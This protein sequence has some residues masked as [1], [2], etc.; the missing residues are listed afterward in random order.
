MT[1]LQALRTDYRAR[2]AQLLDLVASP[3]AT[4]RQVR[5]VL[6][7]MADLT[8]EVLKRLWSGAGLAE[9]YALLA[10]GGYGRAELFPHSDVDVLVLLPDGHSADADSE[11]KK[12]IETFIGN[13]WDVGLEIGSSVRT[14][15]DCL[16]EAEKDVTVQT[17]LLECRLITGN[18]ELVQA[19]RTAFTEA[20]DPKAFFVAKTLE[21]RQRHTKFE[22][23]PY[24]LEPNC[25]ESPGG[26]RDLQVILWVA[27][28]A[29]YGNNWG[30][31]ARGG[32]ATEFEVKQIERN[33]AL[34]LLI[35]AKLHYVAKRREDRLIFDLQNAV[36]ESF[37]YTV[38]SPEGDRRQLVRASEALMKRYYWA[39][40]A[41]T[42][43]NQILLM[44]IEERLNPSTHA[45]R[46]INDHFND[47]AGMIDVVSDDLYRR[48]PH[49]ILE[50]FLVYQTTVG[51]KGLSARTLRALYNARDLMDA[52]YRRDPVNRATFLQIMQAP[53]GITHAMRLMNQ[54]SVLGRYLWVFRKIVGQMQHDL[55]HVYTVD[56][57]ILMV[58][59]NARRFF[60]VEHAHEYPFCSQL[61]SGWDKPWILYIASL[62][63]D[64]AK[65]RGGDHSEL[66]IVEARRFCKEHGVPTEDAKL[67]EFLVGEHLTMSRIAQKSDLSDPDVIREF[68]KRVGNERYLT[69]LYLLTVAD[70]RGTSPKVWNAWKGKLLEDLYKYT[71]RALG[72]RAPDPDAEVEQRKREALVMV[73]L[74]AL[75]FEA[76]KPLW[77]TLDV[78]YFMRHDAADI[79]WHTKQLSRLVATNHPIVRARRS[80]VGE[81]LQVVVYTQ[82]QPDLF[83]RICGYF[84]QGG[85]SILDAR[86]HTT[87][88]GYALDTFQVVT[89]ADM[90]EH[91]REM[92]SLLENGLAQA[93]AEAG[94][95]PAPSRGRVSRRVKSF[96]IA[97]RVSLKPDEKAQRWLLNIS[98][99]DRLGLLYCIARVL[100]KHQIVVQLAK[101]A[102]L[103]ER[104]EDTF[105]IH[106]AQ[107]QHNRA[108]IDIETEILDALSV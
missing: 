86:I 62:F 91:Y 16:Q 65:G 36:A 10:V 41:V 6:Q 46:R 63:H 104:V 9:P 30:D 81:G 45:P 108:Q 60:M 21:M 93:I 106:G 73:A 79:A 32:L 11:L 77:D 102:T 4:V 35:R 89:S 1:E 82:D 88:K 38:G 51:I 84:D 75:P 78:G 28:A 99:S 43:L 13:C 68:A 8:D 87:N 49:A 18:A 14:L 33:E 80:P 76:H 94:P 48:N 44:N 5:K 71:A 26:L 100:A 42:Q 56:Q 3:K 34:L 50:T 29:G 39:A 22:D 95:L 83:A 17:A 58:L 12:R 97:P 64:I 92:T 20:M 2:K 103:G 40:K 37:G 25:K 47:K 24:S 23:T 57:H 31:L 90:D 85:F 101:V 70:I 19:F 7:L 59:R 98:A 69:A 74:Y 61:A 27:K 105:L 55:F 107:L 96:P 54:T 53:D 67:I 15:A 66:G 52:K 72:G